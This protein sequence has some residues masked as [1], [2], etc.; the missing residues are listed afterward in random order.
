MAI[1]AAFLDSA[2]PPAPPHNLTVLDIGTT[3]ATLSWE[4]P[5]GELESPEIAR[6]IVTAI[7]ASGGS[8]LSASTADSATVLTL[9]NL[10]PDTL[11]RF[12]VQSVAEKLGVANPGTPSASVTGITASMG[13]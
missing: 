13:N 9:R 4:Q 2:V 3:W 11:Y 10:L 8:V 5:H 7:P 12:S 1:T 6:Y